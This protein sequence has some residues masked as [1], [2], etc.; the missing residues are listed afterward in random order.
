M[1]SRLCP[2]RNYFRTWAPEETNERRRQSDT[3]RPTATSPPAGIGQGKKIEGSLKAA[4]TIRNIAKYTEVTHR[5]PAAT[6]PPY[7]PQRN[8]SIHRARTL[9]RL[10]GTTRFFAE[11]SGSINRGIQ[12]GIRSRLANLRTPVRHD[13]HS[14]NSLSRNDRRRRTSGR[15]HPSARKTSSTRPVYSRVDWRFGKP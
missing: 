5:R 13:G 9:P 3:R 8:Q 11:S 12:Q 15:I 2:N 4:K 6:H 10:A 7:Q 14:R 1:I